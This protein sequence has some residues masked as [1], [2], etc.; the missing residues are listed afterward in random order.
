MNV[1]ICRAPG[2][3]I[4]RILRCPTCK[5]RRRFAGH[6]YVWYGPTFTCCGCGDS[7]T[8][9]E[10]HDRPR[11]RGWRAV[12]IAA[13]KET[14][15]EAG[16]YTKAEHEEWLKEQLTGPAPKTHAPA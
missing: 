15:E 3:P 8:D 1:I 9:G 14:W 4:R 5:Q 11:R 2:F 6:D 16:Q 7:W 12:E 10:R 13:A